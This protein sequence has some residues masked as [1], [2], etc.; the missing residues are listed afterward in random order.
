M[1][2]RPHYKEYAMK[3]LFV[4]SLTLAFS[5]ITLPV[6]AQEDFS[7]VE[8]EVTQVSGNVWALISGRG[9]NIGVSSGPDGVLM[10]DD[11]FAP[12]ADKIRAA[13]QKAGTSSDIKFLLNTH[14]HGDHTG[15]NIEFGEEATIIAHTN[16][17]ERL[18]APGDATAQ[19][20]PVITFDEALSIH[21]NGEE[22]RAFHIPNG[23]TDGDAAIHFTGSNVLHM[24]DAFFSGL[25]PFVDI[26][27]GGSIE[28]VERGVSDIL[29]HIS[30]DISIIP[31]HGPLSTVEDLEL[32]HRMLLETVAM[33]EQK[34]ERGLSIEQIQ[35]E[36]VAE[37]WSEWGTGFVS[38][39]RWLDTLYRSLSGSSDGDYVEHGHETTN[40]SSQ[41]REKR[42]GRQKGTGTHPN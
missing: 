26:A 17:R 37:E 6:A 1:H 34:M 39:D 30:E 23:H 9:G 42:S 41:N 28:G 18:A 36:G 2:S 27:S 7:D 11:Q 19:A 35:D 38:T 5:M 29:Q 22:I 8:F 33:V 20:L 3:A 14:F 12:L 15:G 13:L 40:S 4:F 24:G 25:F 21:F 16:V 31:G 32:Y 10:I